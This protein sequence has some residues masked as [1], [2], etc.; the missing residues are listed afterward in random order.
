MKRLMEE[1]RTW[2]VEAIHYS[3]P[4]GIRVGGDKSVGAGNDTDF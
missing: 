4:T 2:H 3:A 1:A